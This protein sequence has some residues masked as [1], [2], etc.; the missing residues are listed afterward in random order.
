[1]VFPLWL[2]SLSLGRARLVFGSI[3]N[4]AADGKRLRAIDHFADLEEFGRM[5]G[6]LPNCAA[7]WPVNQPA[8]FRLWV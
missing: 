5:A 8:C 6:K 3:V 7:A 4:A 2:F 1:M